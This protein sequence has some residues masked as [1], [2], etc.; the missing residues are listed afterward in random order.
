MQWA[1]H[2]YYLRTAKVEIVSKVVKS[3]APKSFRR[4]QD[5]EVSHHKNV[6][7]IIPFYLPNDQAEQDC[8]AIHPPCLVVMRAPPKLTSS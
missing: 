4:D 8:I 5:D 6:G 7:M 1:S 2:L 3:S